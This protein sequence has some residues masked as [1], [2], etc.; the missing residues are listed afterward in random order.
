VGLSL[1]LVEGPSLVPAWGLMAATPAVETWARVS[2]AGTL[3][4]RG[5]GAR[6]VARARVATHAAIPATRLPTVLPAREEE[7][8][9]A[10][11]TP[12]ASSL[13]TLAASGEVRVR[14]G[15]KARPAAGITTL[16][17]CP[18]PTKKDPT[19]KDPTKEAQANGM[20]G[21]PVPAVP[22]SRLRVPAVAGRWRVAPPRVAPPILLE[23]PCRCTEGEEVRGTGRG[24]RGRLGDLVSPCRA[25]EGGS[26]GGMPPCPVGLSCQGAA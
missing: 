25:W 16:V 13:P 23:E 2:E 18:P 15:G 5:L 11:G 8:E 24:G 12:G 6:A 1:G 14:E 21:I 4:A 19:K 17:P 22:V 10:G 9:V 3:V 7:E 26:M 20:Q